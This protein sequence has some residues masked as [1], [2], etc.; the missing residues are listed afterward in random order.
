M[1]LA[2]TL[3]PAWLALLPA[4]TTG[5]QTFTGIDQVGGFNVTCPLNDY[6]L[7]PC[8][9]SLAVPP[10]QCPNLQACSP[11][12]EPPPDHS[13]IVIPIACSCL[14]LTN[15]PDTCTSDGPVDELVSSTTTTP[16]GDDETA[17]ATA[18]TAVPAPAVA[19]PVP[20]PVS[21]TTTLVS[22][23]TTSGGGGVGRRPFG[24][25]ASLWM[26]VVWWWIL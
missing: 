12:F 6:L 10:E 13:T 20:T 16:I 26:I 7:S 14:Q 15:C 9:P 19:A 24:V 17:T 8:M 1:K 21:S 3:A 5:L 11:A 4:V 22:P 2:V 25:A 23:G 18:T